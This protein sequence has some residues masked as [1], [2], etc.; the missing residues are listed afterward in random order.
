MSHVNIATVLIF[1]YVRYVEPLKLFVLNGDDFEVANEVCDMG[2]S[3][4]GHWRGTCH[5]YWRGILTP[6]SPSVCIIIMFICIY[7]RHMQ[8]VADT[9]LVALKSYL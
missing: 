1:S 8:S 3:G 2:C 5:I 4:G 7:V 6:K 9:L